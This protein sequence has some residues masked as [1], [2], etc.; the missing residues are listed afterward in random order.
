[1]VDRALKVQALSEGGLEV[2]Y[3]TR[4]GHTVVR[5]GIGLCGRSSLSKDVGAFDPAVLA[6]DE[7]WCDTVFIGAIWDGATGEEGANDAE[8]TVGG[9]KV[10]RGRAGCA[11]DGR[12]CVAVAVRVAT[13][14]SGGVC[15]R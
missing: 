15:E 7:L 10:E 6:S 4:R 1:M 14:E 12:G 3:R 5:E 8:M 2:L 13:G 9:R 11:D